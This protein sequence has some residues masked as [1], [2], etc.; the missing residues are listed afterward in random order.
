MLLDTGALHAWHSPWHPEETE[1]DRRPECAWTILLPFFNERLFLAGTLSSLAVQDQPLKLIL[2]DNASTDGSG[3]FAMAECRRLGLHFTLIREPRPGKVN[4]LAAGLGL[5]R[6]PFVATCDADTWYPADYLSQAGKLL[7]ADDSAAAGAYFLREGAPR[8]QQVAK[9]WH[10][11]IVAALLPRQC[12]TGGAGQVFRTA[13][14][15]RSGGFDA[16]RWNYVLEDHEIMH[17]VVNTGSLEYGPGF[18]CMPS[19]RD[20]DR[21]SIRW[22]LA[23]RLL[24]HVAPPQWRDRFFYEFLGPRLKARRLTS[25]RMRER[26]F[27]NAGPTGHVEGQNNGLQSDATPYSVCG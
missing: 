7:E 6:T 2:I 22:T 16:S 27:Q 23:E 1:S 9:A 24:Y 14:L 3:E 20:R 8:R 12:H 15:R 19:H 11:M 21:D 13:S 18:W 26:Q 4:A 10:I 17:R 5:V 25:E